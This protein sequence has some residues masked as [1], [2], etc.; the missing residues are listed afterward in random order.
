M[1]D[2]LFFKECSL[3]LQCNLSTNTLFLCRKNHISPFLFRL[4]EDDDDLRHQK[5]RFSQI[6]AIFYCQTLPCG[7]GRG[8]P[9]LYPSQV[10]YMSQS[11]H[12]FTMALLTVMI[13]LVDSPFLSM[14]RQFVII[15]IIIS[16]GVFVTCSSL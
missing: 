15:I 2:Q 6:M 7:G 8:P 4:R 14:R 3:L 12:L 1:V 10:Y 16:D 11:Q 9:S 13:C 5:T